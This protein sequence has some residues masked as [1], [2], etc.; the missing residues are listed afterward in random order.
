VKYERRLAWN[1]RWN[2]AEP[3]LMRWHVSYASVQSS[4]PVMLN[5][6]K[7]RRLVIR[8][9]AEGHK[10]QPVKRGARIA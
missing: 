2:S 7:R 8:P 3:P 6:R 4:H 10:V 1:H 9:I 5:S